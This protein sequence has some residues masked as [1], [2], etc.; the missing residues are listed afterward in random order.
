MADERRDD[1]W[2]GSMKRPWYNP[3]ARKGG[4]GAGRGAWRWTIAVIA[5]VV[6]ACV[7]VLALVE[8]DVLPRAWAYGVLPVAI[9]AA[10][11]SRVVTILKA[12]S[13]ES[14]DDGEAR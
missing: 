3:P 14:P 11:L 6:V 7:V 1:D 4:S 5:L 13:E 2:K 10:A 9:F 12:R 8:Q